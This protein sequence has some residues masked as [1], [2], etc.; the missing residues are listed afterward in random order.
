[1]VNIHKGVTCDGCGQYPILGTRYK[2]NTCSDYD[3]CEKCF[4]QLKSSPFHYAP[5]TFHAIGDD[6]KQ[7][8]PGDL[9]L[10]K[11][12]S[13]LKKAQAWLDK[14]CNSNYGGTEMLRVISRV[15]NRVLATRK[16]GQKYQD[17][18]LFMTDGDVYGQQEPEMVKLISKH[19][20]ITFFSMGIGHSHSTTLVENLAR[21]GNGYCSHVFFSEDVPEQVQIIMRCLNTAH[22][23]NASLVWDDCVV[24]YASVKPTGLLFENEPHYVVAKVKSMGEN[25]RVTLKTNCRNLEKTVVTLKLKDLPTSQFPLD[26]SF[27]MTQLKEWLNKP[28]HEMSTAE[29]SRRIIPLAIK[30]NVITPYTAAVGV[31]KSNTT[32]ASS[33][34]MKKIHIPIATPPRGKDN[35]VDSS[36]LLKCARTSPLDGD[37]ILLL[38]DCVRSPPLDDDCLIYTEYI[39]N[40]CQT[41]SKTLG[42]GNGGFFGNFR[43]AFKNPFTSGNR[44]WNRPGNTA[45]FQDCRSRD[46]SRDDQLTKSLPP[47]NFIDRSSRKSFVDDDGYAGGREGCAGGRTGPDLSKSIVTPVVKVN[48]IQNYSDTAVMEQLIKSQR[49]GYWTME[50]IEK[51]GL[52]LCLPPTCVVDK[53]LLPTYLVV[54]FFHRLMGQH[55]RWDTSNKKAL[56]WLAANNTDGRLMLDQTTLLR[57]AGQ[58]TGDFTQK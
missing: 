49:N 2:C 6:E 46:D 56:A 5:H 58:L 12:D 31:V 3:L 1:M 9:W 34:V 16:E 53:K 32:S 39:E 47:K 45:G 38:S 26:Q 15:Y 41:K 54:V 20:D 36:L 19:Q 52:R 37:R 30:Y 44:S 25:P 48:D 33:T 23:R 51:T 57:L 42:T 50:D 40:A 27:A 29:K 10:E 4:A 7:D 35:T 18:I 14:N 24:E 28:N 11:T 21:A 55:S 22:L 43:K 8:Q 17:M 13:N